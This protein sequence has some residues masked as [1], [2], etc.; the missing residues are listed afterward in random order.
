MRGKNHTFKV[1]GSGDELSWAEIP[2]KT[3]KEIINSGISEEMKD[4]LF[5]DSENGITSDITIQIDGKSIDFNIDHLD[6]NVAIKK[7][8]SGNPKK[9]YFL[10]VL[11]LQG[12]FYETVIE[13]PVDLKKITL[14]KES[15]Q[16]GNVALE[17]I[18]YS[19]RYDGQE[20]IEDF[21][22]SDREFNG[23]SYY[24]LSPKGEI[25]EVNSAE[26]SEGEDDDGDNLIEVSTQ[27]KRLYVF[28]DKKSF[29]NFNK[30]IEEELKPRISE[31]LDEISE[32]RPE[33]KGKNH[34]EVLLIGRELDLDSLPSPHLGW[35]QEEIGN[36]TVE[37]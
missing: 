36:F 30:W 31:G 8:N 29:D 19:I 35:V 12:L 25:I 32:I 27:S 33:V 18:F 22:F 10:E 9:W 21:D 1:Y 28:K 16:V 26:D 37:K 7:W 15:H 5:L 4:D 20:R 2:S 11:G 14:H 23:G 24:I 13:G 17:Q 3:A 34:F 6:K